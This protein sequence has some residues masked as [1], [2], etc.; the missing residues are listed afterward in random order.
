MTESVSVFI[1]TR[2][3]RLA[4][5]TCLSKCL[6]NS[7][8][9]IPIFILNPR[10][11][12][13]NKYKSDAAVQ[14]MCESL[15]DLNKDLTAV[16]SK[17]FLFYGNA[18]DV[19]A[20]IYKKIRFNAVYMTQD[21][22][23]FAQERER[24]I[25]KLLKYISDRARTEITF[26]T[27]ED[28]MLCGSIFAVEKTAKENPESNFA[29]YVKFTPYCDKAAKVPVRPPSGT[30]RLNFITSKLAL[31]DIPLGELSNIYIYNQH[32][33]VHGGRKAAITVLKNAA[34]QTKY[35]ETRDM[36]SLDLRKSSFSK[37]DKTRQLLVETTKLSAYI[38]FGCLSIR[39]VYYSF[40][41]S[42]SK[43]NKLFTQLRWR[44]FYTQL[45]YFAPN[46]QP[47]PRD[48][49]WDNN[50]AYFKKWTT[51]STGF[52]IVD[53]GMRQLNKTGWM[54]N[55]LRLITACFLIKILRID[56]RWGERYFAT[57]LVD[58][59]MSQN[60]GN[61]L[62]VSGFGADSQPY[63]RIFNPWLQSAKFDKSAA[64]IK[65]WV[66]ELANVDPS[67]IHNWYAVQKNVSYPAPMVD[68]HK[69]AKLTIKAYKKV[70]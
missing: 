46:H 8:L 43:S 65:F 35:N 23:L 17:L 22:T 19:I 60:N 40:A 55:R 54:H 38:K 28:Y 31:G 9:V 5:N 6:T 45:L 34:Q 13:K 7:G 39:E 70:L 15:V 24:D 10:Q 30:K 48:I 53:A 62:W 58:Y 25:V 64:F 50:V 51:G 41:R 49:A 44:D 63:F 16:G 14:F 21:Y 3:L 36:L 67:D 33:A 27:A 47:K 32:L 61:W 57:K 1:F 29:N 37:P 2:D 42:L 4:D 20:S 69:E 11:L 68:F 26:H 12:D 56:W 59:D 66:P 52:P 18:V